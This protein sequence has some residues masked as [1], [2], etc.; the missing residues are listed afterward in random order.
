MSMVTGMQ[1]NSGMNEEKY[2]SNFNSGNQLLIYRVKT[3]CQS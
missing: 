1:R 3:E 2:M